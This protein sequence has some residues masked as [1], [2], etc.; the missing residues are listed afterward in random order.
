MIRDAFWPQKALLRAC[1]GFADATGI[2]TQVRRFIAKYS[3]KCRGV[4]PAAR[5]SP[6]RSWKSKFLKVNG[7]KDF[8][9]NFD[10]ISMWEDRIAHRPAERSR[11]HCLSFTR[12]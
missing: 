4:R 8:R 1:V 11:D 7:F 12:L 3:G 9:P 10:E 5:L 2:V 6:S